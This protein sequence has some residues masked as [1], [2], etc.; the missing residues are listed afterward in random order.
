M[1]TDI[2]TFAYVHI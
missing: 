2:Y 1:F